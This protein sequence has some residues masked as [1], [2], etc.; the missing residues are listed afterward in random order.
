M[1]QVKG[2]NEGLWNK[3]ASGQTYREKTGFQNLKLASI[4]QNY[5]NIIIIS[6]SRS[7]LPTVMF[8]KRKKT[9]KEVL[10]TC[11][12]THKH[13][14]NTRIKTSFCHFL[15]QIRGF[16]GGWV[17]K[18]TPANAGDMGHENTLEE[19]MVTHFR[20]LAWRIPRTEKPWGL[21]PMKVQK[22]QTPLRD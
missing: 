6:A 20:I 13:E 9:K 3:S 8:P 21:Q 22:S 11:G 18:N 7:N 19:G 15:S 14:A 10:K 16:L 12:V 4:A 5:R 2:R 17:V 1:N